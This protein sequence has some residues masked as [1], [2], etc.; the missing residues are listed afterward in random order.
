MFLRDIF[1]KKYLDTI[2]LKKNNVEGKL[3]IVNLI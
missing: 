2:I 1:S 3:K